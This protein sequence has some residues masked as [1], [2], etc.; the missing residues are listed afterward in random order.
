MMKKRRVVVEFGK[1]DL[2]T[3]LG[4]STS[5]LASVRCAVRANMVLMAA[6]GF[7]DSVIARELDVGCY[8]RQHLRI[9]TPVLSQVF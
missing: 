7:A 1:D 2:E 8:V 5:S 4:W 9:G 3:L 6:A